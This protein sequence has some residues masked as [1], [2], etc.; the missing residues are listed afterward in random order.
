MELSLIHIVI[1]LLLLDSVFAVVIAFV[2]QR[3]YLDTFAPIAR[4]FPPAKGWAILYLVLTVL[5]AV[6]VGWLY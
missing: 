5:M 6:M 2:G 1:G 3:W 4:W